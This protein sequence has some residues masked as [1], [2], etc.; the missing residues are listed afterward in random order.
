C[1]SLRGWDIGFTKGGWLTATNCD[2]GWPGNT[3]SNDQDRSG[4]AL[5]VR[6]GVLAANTG[7]P[8]LGAVFGGAR[9]SIRQSK[10]GPLHDLVSGSDY[11]GCG[12]RLEVQYCRT[13]HCERDG[14]G[15]E[16]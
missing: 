2:N 5:P 1:A 8:L 3:T 14:A 10:C 11:R 9:S 4:H 6:R 12:A 15:L 7:L 13:S 16:G